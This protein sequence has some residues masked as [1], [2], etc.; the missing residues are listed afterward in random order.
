MVEDGRHGIRVGTVDPA[1]V[2]IDLNG[3]SLTG[4]GQSFGANV[5]GIY[6][7]SED[8]RVEVRNGRID[9]RPAGGIFLNGSGSVS[10]V[11][12][13]ACSF[14]GIEIAGG[15]AG[16]GASRSSSVARCAT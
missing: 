1:G 2:Q 12:V 4:P 9:R 8:T 14:R 7:V 10:G 3:F 13:A 11:F 6:G 5:L 15:P 16:A